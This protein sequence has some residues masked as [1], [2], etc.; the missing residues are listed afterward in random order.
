MLRCLKGALH[1]LQASIQLCHVQHL[2]TTTPCNTR[3]RG[4]RRQ[5]RPPAGHLVASRQGAMQARLWDVGYGAKRGD[6]HGQESVR[7]MPEHESKYVEMR[8]NSSNIQEKHE[9]L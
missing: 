2:L 3:R 8:T 6:L 4:Q 5:G 1:L 9:E 7:K